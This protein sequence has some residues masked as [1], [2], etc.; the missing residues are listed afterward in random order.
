MA[1][2]AAWILALA[3]PLAVRVL[4]ALGIGWVTY[5]GVN[6]LATSVINSAGGLWGGLTGN[7]LRMATLLGL[8]DALAIMLGA[9]TARAALVAI[10]RLGKL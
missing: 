4:A 7:V 3:T 10:A 2:L 5:E 8:S 1:N 6:V 9:L